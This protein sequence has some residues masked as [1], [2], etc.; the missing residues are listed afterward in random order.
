MFFFFK[1]FTSFKGLVG[2]VPDVP[3]TLQINTNVDRFNIYYLILEKK[4]HQLLYIY[5]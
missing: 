1:S 5:Y 3:K 2:I 4:N